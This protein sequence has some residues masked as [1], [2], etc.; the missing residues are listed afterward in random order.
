M[1]KYATIFNAAMTK[2]AELNSL[3]PLANPKL[4]KRMQQ[5]AQVLPHS[6][7]YSY[8]KG[9]KSFDV[10]HNNKGIEDYNKRLASVGRTNMLTVMPHPVAPKAPMTSFANDAKQPKQ[11]GQAASGATTGG[12]AKAPN[13]KPNLSKAT[14]PAGANASGLGS[15]KEDKP[16]KV[17]KNS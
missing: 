8:G 2:V 10:W 7:P 16:V 13:S 9:P 1:N 15:W 14:L 12:L 17:S 4:F 5:M 6:R 3:L 11:M